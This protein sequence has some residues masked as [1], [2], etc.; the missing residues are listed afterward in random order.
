MNAFL[1][2][3]Q[4]RNGMYV[5]HGTNLKHSWLETA[6][7]TLSCILSVGLGELI[8][9]F[10]EPLGFEF[11]TTTHYKV[12]INYLIPCL[13]G[14]Q[15]PLYPKWITIIFT[16]L[17]H[18]LYVAQHL[19]FW[20]EIPSKCNKNKIGAATPT[21]AKRHG[22]WSG[23]AKC[24]RSALTGLQ[25]FFTVLRILLPLNSLNP[26]WDGSQ[27]CNIKNLKNPIITYVIEFSVKSPFLCPLLGP[28]FTPYTLFQWYPQ[29]R[30]ILSNLSMKY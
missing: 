24:R 8:S 2:C 9:A 7:C 30:E 21:K 20:C 10:S 15:Y 13:I 16:L 22:F 4:L 25:N 3:L 5:N 12:S 17:I 19:I 27:W 26:F 14:T 28:T 23:L 29:S 11:K 18:F 6:E 1:L